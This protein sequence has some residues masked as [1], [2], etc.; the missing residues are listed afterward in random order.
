M[1][2]S[3]NHDDVTVT[4][5]CPRQKTQ[6]I[7]QLGSL[8]TSRHIHHHQ[9]I[10]YCHQLPSQ[11]RDLKFESPPRRHRRTHLGNAQPK[12]QRQTRAHRLMCKRTSSRSPMF[13]LPF[14]KTPSLKTLKRQKQK[15]WVPRHSW[16][17]TRSTQGSLDDESCHERAPIAITWRGKEPMNVPPH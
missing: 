7:A 10:R 12:V 17:E 4:I 14:T 13:H 3:V 15:P 9:H 6:M 8:P 1:M 16:P 2:E 5:L 11:T